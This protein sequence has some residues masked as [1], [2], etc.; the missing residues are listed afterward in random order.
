M[1]G[2]K[3]SNWEMEYLKKW[4]SKIPT[5]EICEKLNRSRSAVWRQSKRL[6][7]EFTKPKVKKCCHCNKELP[8]TKE[9]FFTKK[10]RNK[11][12]DGTFKE[13][14]IFRSTCKRCHSLIL[15]EKSRQ[16]R[17]KELGV[18][19]MDDYKKAYIFQGKQSKR[20]NPEIFELNISEEEKRKINWWCLRYNY[21]FT[22][23]EDFYKKKESNYGDLLRKSK[24]YKG[25][26]PDGYNRYKDLPKTELSKLL[27][28]RLT[29]SK[30]AN[31]L[32]MP[33][34]ECPKE[35]IEAKRLTYQI[36]RLIEEID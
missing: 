19:N 18:D 5:S 9:Y 36:N 16:K 34:S 4:Y 21:K 6:G 20:K 7:L 17:F 25:D 24:R 28:N 23:L 12:K 31:W 2:V 8:K 35:M 29:D 15:T 30:V 3:W 14:V 27:Q 32:G 33:V 22:T 13:Y 11:L 10:Q 1:A 26:L